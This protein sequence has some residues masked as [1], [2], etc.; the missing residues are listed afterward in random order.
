MNVGN[1]EPCCC[2]LRRDRHLTQLQ[3]FRNSP[4]QFFLA[5]SFGARER[6]LVFGIQAGNLAFVVKGIERS[7]RV[8]LAIIRVRWACRVATLLRFP[9]TQ[10]S[11]SRK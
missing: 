11:Q 3:P 10:N 2:A 9:V 8:V 4:M 6:A 7:L 1:N 5:E